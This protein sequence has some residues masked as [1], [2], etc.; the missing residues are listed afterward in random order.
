MCGAQFESLFPGLNSFG[1]DRQIA[2]MM[3]HAAPDRHLPEIDRVL[4]GVPATWPRDRAADRKDQARRYRTAAEALEDLKRGTTAET[5]VTQ[6]QQEAAAKAAK[7]AK[8]KRWLSIAAFVGSV[9]VSLAAVFWP[10]RIRCRRRRPPSCVPPRAS[11]AT[12]TSN[13]AFSFETREEH[14]TPQGVSIDAEQDRVYLNEQRV[15][16]GELGPTTP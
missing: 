13:A 10:T 6:E 11:S 9:A 16:L 4:Q 7:Q 15:S 12:S 3:W 2:W 5:A 14:E 8:R 1:R